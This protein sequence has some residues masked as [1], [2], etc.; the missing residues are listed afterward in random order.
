MLR[1]TDS[2]RAVSEG[3]RST[4]GSGIKQT[5]NNR[6]NKALVRLHISALL[7]VLLG[8]GFY[9][10]FSLLAEGDR[11]AMAAG[12]V[13]AIVC[14]ALAVVVEIIAWEIRRRYYW[15]WIAG[16][17]T[18]ALYVPSIFM[19][20]GILGVWWLMDDRSRAEFGS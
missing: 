14:C 19:P 11:E 20:L 13:I 17:G 6:I 9:F 3:L 2:I 7:Y 1:A 15:A 18:F 8:L 16:V 5:M 10:L 4:T 12:V